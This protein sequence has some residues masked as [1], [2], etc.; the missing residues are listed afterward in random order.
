MKRTLTLAAVALALLP[1]VAVSGGAAAQAAA[2]PPEAPWVFVTNFDGEKADDT[3]RAD[4][5]ATDAQTLDTA[6]GDNGCGTSAAGAYG[7]LRSYDIDVTRKPPVA[8]ANKPLPVATWAGARFL[9]SSDGPVDVKVTWSARNVRDC[10]NCTTAAYIGGSPARAGGDFDLV[11][12][13]GG[14]WQQFGHKA[15]VD[16]VDSNGLFVA[17]GWMG[18]NAT[19]GL[20]CITVEARPAQPAVGDETSASRR[21]WDYAAPR[22]QHD[23]ATAPEQLLLRLRGRARALGLRHR[24]DLWVASAAARRERLP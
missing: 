6:S 23:Q 24:W 15:R 14:G 19:I 16:L 8:G 21:R 13:L 4:G 18:G 2:P 3:W 22:Q 7:A 20:D 17:I 5:D 12:E 11:G 10:E 9:I 1:A